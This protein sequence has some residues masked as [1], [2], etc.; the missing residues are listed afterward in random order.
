M[1]VLLAVLGLAGLIGAAN[2]PVAACVPVAVIAAPPAPRAVD[3]PSVLSLPT[4]GAAPTAA[5]FVQPVDVDDDDDA[6]I[7][8]DGGDVARTR[9]FP[10]V[11]IAVVPHGRPIA[12]QASRVRSIGARVG[13]DVPRAPPSTPPI[14]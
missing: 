9:R 6:A 3:P 14:V 5:P 11:S 7:D 2:Q 8:D 10:L 12:A 13:S 1:C 4:R